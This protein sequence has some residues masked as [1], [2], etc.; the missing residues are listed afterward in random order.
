MINL[1]YLNFI[2][3]I[4]LFFVSLFF[5][6]SHRFIVYSLFKY[7]IFLSIFN[8]PPHLILPSDTFPHNSSLFL[9]LTFFVPF[10]L[11]PSSSSSP[12]SISSI[13]CP[14]LYYVHVPSPIIS[15]S[16]PLIFL[17]DSVPVI[18]LSSSS[19]H[20]FPSL[21]SSSSSILSPHPFSSRFFCYF[22]FILFY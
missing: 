15:P 12:Y 1:V 2:I 8:F 10:H 4:F 22:S 18:S 14:S 16:F 5:I 3:I 9:H 21:S 17:S 11:S 6:F 7:Y 20:I 19:H 13:S